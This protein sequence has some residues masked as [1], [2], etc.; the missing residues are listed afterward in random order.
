[1]LRRLE[2][3]SSAQIGLLTVAGL[4][5][6]WSGSGSDVPRPPER[7]REKLVENLNRGTGLWL[8][9]GWNRC[10]HMLC[11]QRNY[12][13]MLSPGL[14]AHGVAVGAFLRGAEAALAR[15]HCDHPQHPKERGDPQPGS[16]KTISGPILR[17]CFARRANQ[18]RAVAA[19]A[20]CF[21]KWK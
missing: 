14:S 21:L 12:C 11:F 4:L 19:S 13:D 5:V 1:M 7:C 16:G 18:R 20:I 9:A 2:R 3:F 15:T 8:G 10:L 17:P 6:C